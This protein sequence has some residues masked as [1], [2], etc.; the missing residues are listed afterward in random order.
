MDAA[1]YFFD[2]ALHCLVLQG[3]LRRLDVFCRDERG[4]LLVV[5]AEACQQALV[6]LL[7]GLERAWSCLLVEFD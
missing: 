1:D 5:W 4:E 7:D 6:L 3:V 2:L